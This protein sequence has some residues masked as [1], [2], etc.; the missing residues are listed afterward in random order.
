VSTDYFGDGALLSNDP[1]IFESAFNRKELLT[2]EN[3]VINGI[4][5]YNYN[6]NG[7][8]ISTIYSS[9][10]NDYSEKS[11]FT[12]D[13]NGRIDRQTI[14][15]D[16]K[17]AGYI[18]YMY[19]GRGNLTK[20]T[21]YSLSSSGEAELNTTRQYE[22]DNNKN[23]FRVFFKLMIP[24]INTNLNNVTRETFTI[25]FKPGQG[26][27]IVQTTLTSYTYNSNGYPVKKNG[28]VEFIYE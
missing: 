12:C 7:Q 13:I 24:G 28:T 11:E 21:L 19:D 18:N 20:E 23:P 5:K 3:S 25:H 14:F 27:D 15:W 16:N 8:L 9:P 10:S 2:P 4:L 17:V 22:Y 6:D 26:S 1:A